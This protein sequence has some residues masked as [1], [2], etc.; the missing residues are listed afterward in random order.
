MLRVLESVPQIVCHTGLVLNQIC[1]S[2]L[3]GEHMSINSSVGWLA[4][5]HTRLI[6][7]L[8]GIV[9]QYLFDR[10]S[11]A[12]TLVSWNC[13]NVNE[14]PFDSYWG[15]GGVEGRFSLKHFLFCICMQTMISH[16]TFCV[17]WYPYLQN[18]IL[19]FFFGRGKESEIMNIFRSSLRMKCPLWYALEGSYNSIGQVDL[20]FLFNGYCI[21]CTRWRLLNVQFWL[22]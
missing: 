3:Q 17:Y 5:L 2:S 19:K 20:L 10:Q 8:C 6:F 9:I 1:L 22:F 18:P 14:Q 4:Y 21:L 12:W 15:G 13:S 16:F 7:H 11:L